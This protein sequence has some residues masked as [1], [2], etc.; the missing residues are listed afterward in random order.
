MKNALLQ[1]PFSEGIHGLS[2]NQAVWGMR[3]NESD[4]G[5]SSVGRRAVRSV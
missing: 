5:A 2:G 4:S 1:H 3:R